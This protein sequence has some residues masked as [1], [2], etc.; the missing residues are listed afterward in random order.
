MVFAEH[1]AR[2]IQNRHGEASSEFEKATRFRG[3]AFEMHAT[4]KTYVAD[5]Q[6]AEPDIHTTDG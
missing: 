5:L 6:Q 4:V 3:I 2:E 1:Y